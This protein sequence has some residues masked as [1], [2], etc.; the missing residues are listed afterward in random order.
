MISVDKSYSST[1]LLDQAFK[2]SEDIIFSFLYTDFDTQNFGSFRTENEDYL[3]LEDGSD[4]LLNINKGTVDGLAVFLINETCGTTLT[5]GFSAENNLGTNYGINLINDAV[6]PNSLSGITVIAAIDKTGYFSLSSNGSNGSSDLYSSG[7]T[8]L[9]PDRISVRVADRGTTLTAIPT[10]MD[11]KGAVELNSFSNETYDKRFKSF[12][13]GF[14]RHLQDVTIYN[15]TSNMLKPLSTFNTD[16]PLIN[17][18][19]KVRIGI[20]YAGHMPMEIKNI[21]VNGKK[22]G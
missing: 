3:T 22:I 18:T 10:A 19:E 12:A 5:G 6:Y 20:S 11:Y 1:I 16:I 9:K 21:T 4:L 7:E 15:R 14:K 2:S 17:Q 8:T 13:I